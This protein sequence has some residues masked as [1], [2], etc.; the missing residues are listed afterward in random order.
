MYKKSAIFICIAFLLVS[1]CL[2]PLAVVNGCHEPTY[3]SFGKG[4]SVEDSFYYLDSVN[5]SSRIFGFDAAGSLKSLYVSKADKAVDICFN[6][7]KIYVLLNAFSIRKETGVCRSYMIKSFTADLKPVETSASFEIHPGETAVDL[8]VEGDYAYVSSVSTDATF[9][10]GYSV[11]VKE[12]MKLAEAKEEDKDAEASAENE[13]DYYAESVYLQSAPT[14]RFIADAVFRQGFFHIRT[15]A[16][17]ADGFFEENDALRSAL[18]RVHPSFSQQMKLAGDLTVYYI[19]GSAVILVILIMCF[20]VFAGR[21]KTVYTAIAVELVL[22]ALVAV[23]C[24]G[25]ILQKNRYVKDSKEEYAKFVLGV[26]ASENRGINYKTADESWYKSEEYRK[27]QSSVERFVSREYQRDV[28]YD[29][30]VL[31]TLSSKVICG[32]GG[33]NNQKAEELFGEC[34]LW[35]ALGQDVESDFYKMSVPGKGYEAIAVSPYEGSSFTF[36]GLI[37]TGNTGIDFSDPSGI[38]RNSLIL[39]VVA[40][41]ALLAVLWLISGDLRKFDRAIADVAINGH[42]PYLGPKEPLGSDLRNMWNSLHEIEKKID[43]I[44]YSSFK[45][46]EAYYRFPPRNIEKILGLESILDVESGMKTDIH[47]TLCV[48]TGSSSLRYDDRIESLHGLLNYLKDHPEQEGV[49]VSDTDSLTSV[50]LLFDEEAKSTGDFAVDFLRDC[51]ETRSNIK[52]PS[53]FLYHGQFEYGV[54]GTEDQSRVFLL[55]RGSGELINLAKWFRKQNLGVVVTEEIKKRERNAFDYRYIG[56]VYIEESGVEMKL[57]EVLD[58]CPKKE[59]E[60]KIL[61][62]SKFDEAIKLFY[63]NDYYMARNSFSEILK[64]NPSDEIVRWYL[65]ESER[66]L[67]SRGR[68]EYKPG[69]IHIN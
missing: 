7:G 27:L 22:I 38:I 37:D 52:S 13:P 42:S 68:S 69:A 58:G 3:N 60:L 33:K 53:V 11:P 55:S 15:D 8:Y 43:K 21:V 17:Q 64:N 12:L 48:I 40:S 61:Y 63:Q 30:V 36:V 41:A 29:C 2:F 59:R 44:N 65:F 45:R 50:E 56:F 66:L 46:L 24:S 14:G 28:F 32:A 6:D 35:K 47:G 10:E 34:G 1:I 39:F 5:G 19:A 57:Y 49:I 9:A 25:Y 31:D 67:D 54:T 23:F 51:R 26:L 18:S 16:D 20:I 4:I 62:R